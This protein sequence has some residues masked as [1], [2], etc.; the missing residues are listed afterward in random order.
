MPSMIKTPQ[1]PFVMWIRQNTNPEWDFPGNEGNEEGSSSYDYVTGNQLMAALEKVAGSEDKELPFQ[2]YDCR[3][4][5]ERDVF[6]LAEEVTLE[7]GSGE[8][9]TLPL[10]RVQLELFELNT[11]YFLEENFRKDQ[12]ILCACQLGFKSGQAHRYL[13]KKGYNTKI[14]LG[15]MDALPKALLQQ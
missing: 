9:V 3:E 2:I 11:G 15:G 4:G 6:D 14:L 7:V 10:P 1:R 5:Y 13:T 8:D 12:W